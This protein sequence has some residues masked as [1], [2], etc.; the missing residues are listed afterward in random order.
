MVRSAEIMID[1][2]DVCNKIP[3]SEEESSRGMCFRL[4]ANAGADTFLVVFFSS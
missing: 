1:N 4:F 2:L 3:G